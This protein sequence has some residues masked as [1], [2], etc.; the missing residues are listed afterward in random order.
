MLPCLEI[1]HRVCV[2]F[3]K[4]ISLELTRGPRRIF[5]HHPTHCCILR[6]NETSVLIT[7]KMSY[8][9]IDSCIFP[10]IMTVFKPKMRVSFTSFFSRVFPEPFETCCTISCRARQDPHVIGSPCCRDT[11]ANRFLLRT[12]TNGD[13]YQNRS[14][15]CLPSPSDLPVRK[16]RSDLM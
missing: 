16:V 14:L 6:R 15:I 8:L 13:E 5:P 1:C 12:E 7:K 3:E 9:V 11:R 2:E 4:E 10:P